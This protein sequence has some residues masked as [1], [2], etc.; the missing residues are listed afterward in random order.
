[1]GTEGQGWCSI[2]PNE[3][4]W[5]SRLGWWEFGRVRSGKGGEEDGLLANADGVSEDEKEDWFEN[6]WPGLTK[7]NLGI[8]Q[9]ETVIDFPGGERWM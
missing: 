3:F 5:K 1:M 9:E 6:W 2:N 4:S 7:W 8:V